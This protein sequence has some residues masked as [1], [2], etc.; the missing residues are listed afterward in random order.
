MS[1]YWDVRGGARGWEEQLYPDAV[2][3]DDGVEVW[4]TE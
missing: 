1:D 4:T 2:D 3:E